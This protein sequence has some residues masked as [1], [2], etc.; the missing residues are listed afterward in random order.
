MAT[1]NRPSAL[2]PTRK[3]RLMTLM[4]CMLLTACGTTD[5]AGDGTAD[6]QGLNLDTT[7]ATDVSGEGDPAPVTDTSTPAEDTAAPE[8]DTSA[9]AADTAAPEEDATEPAADTA[10]PEADTSA[11]AADTAAPEEDAT[12]PEVDIVDPEEDVVAPEADTATPEEDV[13]EPE[14]DVTEPEQ[15]VTEPEEDVVPPEADV[16]DEGDS[17]DAEAPLDDADM[18]TVLNDDDNCPETPNADQADSD[19][20]GIG[21]A[22]DNCP[23]AQNADQADGDTDGYGD[24]CD[25]CPEAPNADQADG[26]TDGYGDACDNCPETPNLS[27]ADS[28]QDGQGDVCDDTFDGEVNSAGCS[29]G[30]REGFIIGSAYGLIAGCAG[31][32]DV[33]G[34]HHSIGACGNNAGND[35]DNPN[36]V[37]CNVADLC[38]EGW[39]VCLGKSDVQAHN[40]SGCEGIMDGAKGG[41]FFLAR[42]SSTGAFNCAPDTIGSPNSVNDLFGCGDLGCPATESTC[43]PLQLGSHDKCKALNYKPTASCACQF[44]GELPVDD[45]KYAEGDMETVV[46]QPNSGGCGWCKPLDYWAYKL[47][48]DLP[49]TWDCGTNTTAEANN[50]VKTGPELG[51][52]LCC[53]DL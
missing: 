46:C 41:Q 52:V 13:T 28:D 32:W 2:K 53:K 5:G 3:G 15:D 50:V 4:L 30:T 45:P 29:D 49:A 25:N 39:H 6:A 47:G 35:S 9:P 51:G 34:I 18:D 42:T 36:G 16:T 12:E 10:A 37:G 14:Q 11:P 44:A 38:S 27:Q 31:G 19:E 33:P 22:C 43:A 24:I 21:D 48:E 23:E 7:A 40:P 17:D 8:A 26:D 20:D 1:L